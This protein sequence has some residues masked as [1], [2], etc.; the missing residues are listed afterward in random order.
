MKKPKIGD[1]VKATT[2]ESGGIIK[3]EKYGVIA[4]SYSGNVYVRSPETSCYNGNC[5]DTKI[6]HPFSMLNESQYILCGKPC[7][8]NS[9]LPNKVTDSMIGRSLCTNCGA[10]YDCRKEPY[11]SS[12]G[13]PVFNN[14]KPDKNTTTYNGRQYREVKRKAKV[15][16]LVKV[17]NRRGDRCFENGDVCKVLKDYMF[18]RIRT[19]KNSDFGEEPPTCRQ[20]FSLIGDNEYVV[21]EPIEKEQPKPFSKE[22]YKKHNN[23]WL[24]GD[25][26]HWNR[27]NVGW[28]VKCHDEHNHKQDK[29]MTDEP[30]PDIARRSTFRVVIDTGS[31]LYENG[32][33][34]QLTENDNSKC[35]YFKNKTK[36]DRLV[37]CHWYRLI[38]INII[39]KET[40]KDIINNIGKIPK[41]QYTFKRTWTDAEITE[42]KRYVADKMYSLTKDGQF[43]LFYTCKAHPGKTVAQL[44]QVGDEI[45]FGGFAVKDLKITGEEIKTVIAKCCDT[46]T[47][48]DD[49]GK[50]IAVC[51]LFNEPYPTWIRGEHK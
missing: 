38:P 39:H 32:D 5:T 48:N 19:K 23:D 8:K 14:H 11:C 12:C 24:C 44:F 49:I 7:D 18:L 28:C 30:H 13:D 45:V 27:D 25:C 1:W 10:D 21:L 42:A 16:E 15:G 20:P 33:I 43:I 3:G 51:K 47:F 9:V 46:D 4:I 29:P 31:C 22:F 2:N 37:V 6:K 50:M 40:T 41:E 36:D 17:T 35:P 34:L 26:G